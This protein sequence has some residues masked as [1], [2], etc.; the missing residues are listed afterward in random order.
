V[1][2]IISNLFIV[3]CKEKK[4]V[5]II[6]VNF[7][8]RFLSVNRKRNFLTCFHL[9]LYVSGFFFR[10][11]H[12]NRKKKDFFLYFFEKEIYVIRKRILKTFLRLRFLY[13]NRSFLSNRL[14]QS[15]GSTNF[16][17]RACSTRSLNKCDWMA[18][19]C[20]FTIYTFMN[21]NMSSK[22]S[23]IDFRKDNFF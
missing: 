14:N 11:V 18:I 8:S 6:V 21:I 13:V 23:T 10:F 2:G 17:E 5:Y 1:F 3:T 20:Y 16:S 22:K 15:N 19:S 7:V 12:F 4:D 9:F